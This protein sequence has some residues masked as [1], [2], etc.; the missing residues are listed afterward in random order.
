ME[1][2]GGGATF[3][4]IFFDGE[5]DISIGDIKIHS[6]LDFKAFQ[7]MIS[8]RIG[9]SP[10][11]ISIYQVDRKTGHRN[12]VTAKTN[13]AL[14]VRQKDGFFQVILKRSRKARSR[15]PRLNGFDYG[16]YLLD[17][18]YSP[19]SPLEN[20][21]LLRRNQ[22]ELNLNGLQASGYQ[23]PF[24]DQITQAEL[25]GLNDRLQNL[26][27][28]RENY[29]LAMAKQPSFG[30]QNLVPNTGQDLNPYFD[31]PKIQETMTKNVNNKVICEACVNTNRDDT[32]AFHHCVNDP[33]I[34]F[35]SYGAGP[36]A[37]PGKA[38]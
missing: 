8:Q 12:P 20:V 30:N 18:D 6:A 7:L 37:R 15:K 21:I 5:R 33:I 36:I 22:P 27:I 32:S 35:R 34:G 4:V 31:Y 25:A 26:K 14:V 2:G 11:Q 28:Q 1:D 10:N 13:F 23:T 17:S 9:I 29:A 19:P 3:P 24:Y 16:D 38:S